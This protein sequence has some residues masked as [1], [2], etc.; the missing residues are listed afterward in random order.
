MSYL[1]LDVEGDVDV[2]VDTT[3][4]IART[5]PISITTRIILFIM[6]SP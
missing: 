2:D 5:S 1:L 3:M 4:T 6:A